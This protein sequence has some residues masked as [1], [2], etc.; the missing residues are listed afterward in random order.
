M[1]ERIKNDI[2]TPEQKKKFY[3]FLL[4]IYNGKI[5][6]V[7]ESAN[8]NLRGFCWSYKYFFGQTQYKFKL[9]SELRRHKPRKYF[10]DFDG[11]ETDD[12]DQFWFLIDD[13]KKRIKICEKILN[14]LNK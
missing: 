1:V 7:F 11:F 13:N 4:D 8:L 6:V 2:I 5:E 14:E 10:Y 9:L 12:K 3:Q